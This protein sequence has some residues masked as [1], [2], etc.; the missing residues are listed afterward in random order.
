[1]R[2]HPSGDRPW[3]MSPLPFLPI[4]AKI[5]TNDNRLGGMCMGKADKDFEDRLL[6][7]HPIWA[8][9]QELARSWE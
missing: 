1:M 4:L 9:T 6:K 8:C 7:I 5:V 3:G 2:I